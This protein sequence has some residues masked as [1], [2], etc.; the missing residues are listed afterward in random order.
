MRLS[1]HLFPM[2]DL[3]GGFDPGSDAPSFSGIESGAIAARGT[4]GNGLA[5]TAVTYWNA[6]VV[7]S[8][9][10]GNTANIPASHATL[11]RIDVLL[12]DDSWISGTAASG[13]DGTTLS[14]PSITAGRAWLAAVYHR[15]NNEVVKNFDDGAN[16]FMI[17]LN[18][19][20]AETFFRHT[21]TVINLNGG[22][23]GITRAFLTTTPLPIRAA[24]LS[25]YEFM[26]C[27]YVSTASAS[28]RIEVR[29]DDVNMTPAGYNMDALVDGAGAQEVVNSNSLRAHLAAGNHMIEWV[30]TLGVAKVATIYWHNQKI[31]GYK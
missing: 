24:G 20:T 6:G 14:W 30:Y 1:R 26:S 3:G 11:D 15:A 5:Y 7:G 19:V 2:I 25:D 23:G 17:G 27:W 10:T 21:E 4:P 22:G 31:T 12:D 28:L 9:S 13:G 8:H 16:S 18:T 29:V